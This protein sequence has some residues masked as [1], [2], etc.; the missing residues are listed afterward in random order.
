[1]T[2]EPPPGLPRRRFHM[3]ARAWRARAGRL[4]FF[5]CP[6]DVWPSIPCL[7][8]HVSFDSA[9]PTPLA[10]GSLLSDVT[11]PIDLE[12]WPIHTGS[13]R[14]HCCGVSAQR[15]LLSGSQP[16]LRM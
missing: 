10:H 4:R 13:R 3:T 11:L 16:E 7:P 5:L 9:M 14:R 15:R 12:A 6:P 2:C 1:M 8:P